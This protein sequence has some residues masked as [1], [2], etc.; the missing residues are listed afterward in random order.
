MGLA[1]V[2]VFPFVNKL[3]LIIKYYGLYERSVFFVLTI[4]HSLFYKHTLIF[5]RDYWVRQDLGCCF[6][7]GF[8]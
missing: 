1:D 5:S 4:L 2:C 3:E 8:V 6:V 7:W